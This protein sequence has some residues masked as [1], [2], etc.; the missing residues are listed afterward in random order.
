M[1]ALFRGGLISASALAVMQHGDGPNRKGLRAIEHPRGLGG[2][3]HQSTRIGQSTG[4]FYV[5]KEALVL[6]FSSTMSGSGRDLALLEPL[7]SR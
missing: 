3:G 4:T 2:L 1:R 6:L 7:L 5:P